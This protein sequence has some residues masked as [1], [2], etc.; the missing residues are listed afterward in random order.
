MILLPSRCLFTK[1]DLFNIL[2]C[3]TTHLIT[4]CITILVPNVVLCRSVTFLNDLYIY[5]KILP[6]TNHV[7]L[8]SS[9]GSTVQNLHKS[10]IELSEIHSHTCSQVYNI[11]RRVGCPGADDANHVV[12]FQ[13]LHQ[14]IPEVNFRNTV[15]YINT[16]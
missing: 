6:S 10:F 15:S 1:I 7:E 14:S 8:S 16:I 2:S 13:M 9:T 3:E 11:P 12:G 5:H 4:L